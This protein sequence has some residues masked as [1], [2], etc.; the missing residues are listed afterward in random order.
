MNNSPIISVVM[1]VYNAEK[2]LRDSIESI[3]SQSFSNFEFI[4]INDGSSDKSLSII[5]TYRKKDRR[6]ILISRKNKGLSHSLNEGISISRGIYIARMDADDISSRYRLQKQLDF[7][8]SN[9]DIGVCGTSALIISENKKILD[10]TLHAKFD[11]EIRCVMFMNT[12]II[13]GSAMLRKKILFYRDYIYST[14]F[15][16]SQDYELFLYLSRHT[17]FHN[18]ELPLYLFR[19]N[20]NGITSKTNED[21]INL[22]LP[23]FKILLTNNLVNLGFKP[24][25]NE[26]MMAFTLSSNISMQKFKKAP[27]KIEFFL[28]EILKKNNQYNFYDKLTFQKHLSQ[29]FFTFMIISNKF[30]FIRLFYDTFFFNGFYVF[31]KKKILRTI[32]VFIYKLNLKKF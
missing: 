15:K 8:E 26:L 22:R 21:I 28:Y 7:M 30:N 10:C 2:F 27:K 32:I 4:I 23:Y 12:S 25:N 29:K 19:L 24:L 17:K 18:I 9:Q 16:N 3:L 13:H 6:I 31:I 11:K 20:K 5:E 14:Q 1:S